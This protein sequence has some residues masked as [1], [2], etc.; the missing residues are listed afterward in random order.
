[1]QGE[2]FR[3]DF[4]GKGFETADALELDRLS[5]LATGPQCAFRNSHV[6]R[7]AERSGAADIFCCK[8]GDRRFFLAFE[9][10]TVGMNLSEMDFHSRKLSEFIA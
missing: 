10:H 8:I 5:D 6:E 9:M 1:M 7:I 3:L 2:S 4:E